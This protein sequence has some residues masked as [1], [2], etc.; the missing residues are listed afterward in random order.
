[1][2]QTYATRIRRHQYIASLPSGD[3]NSL[4][5]YYF[6]GTGATQNILSGFSSSTYNYSTNEIPNEITGVIF[7]P[8]EKHTGE[9]ISV[10]GYSSMGTD[11]PL[12]GSIPVT[13]PVNPGPN[14]IKIYSQNAMGSTAQGK[15]TRE[16]T[17]NINRA[18]TE[19]PDLAN[20]TIENLTTDFNVDS[21]ATTTYSLSTATG[22]RSVL[23]TPTAIDMNVSDITANVTTGRGNSHTISMANS[24]SSEIVV[25]PGENSISIVVTADNGTATQT[26]TLSIT[27]PES[28]DTS[29]QRIQSFIGASEGTGDQWKIKIGDG[30]TEID[31]LPVLGD[32]SSTVILKDIDSTIIEPISVNPSRYAPSVSSGND[33][34]FTLEVTAENGAIQTHTLTV[35]PPVSGG[36][37]GSG[38]LS[39]IAITMGSFYAT[40]RPLYLSFNSPVT[41][42]TASVFSPSVYDY[43]AVVYG[44]DS[45]KISATAKEGTDVS[46]ITVNGA[47][48]DI[49]GAT[50]TDLY[51]YSGQGYVTPV[52]I[53]VT[54]S[55]GGT[56]AY[57]VQ[58]KLLNIYEFYR[59]VYGSAM[60][61]TYDT[62]W[63]PIKPS[64]LG[65]DEKV[66]GT[67]SGKLHWYVK[68][69]S[70]GCTADSIMNLTNYNDGQMGLPHNN[71][72]IVVAGETL[73]CFTAAKTGYVT[74]GYK[75]Y[76]PE[77]DFVSDL[78]Y[79]LYAY[80]GDKIEKDDAYTDC[81]YMGETIRMK[82]YND[83]N[84]LSK[85]PFDPAYYP[86][87]DYYSSW[88]E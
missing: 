15:Y 87:Y 13:I 46:T 8:Y 43:S 14:A 26:Y 54:D 29:I 38:R 27:T 75:I 67:V 18:Y 4:D 9:H 36:G 47:D 59:G 68:S 5:V 55:S 78:G 21:P 58:V 37:S 72:G 61:I 20:L 41:D 52:Q 63:A 11:W 31:F 30:V 23:I 71:G 86:D 1:M 34:V 48:A 85:S 73:G 44:F 69:S 81:T 32:A 76:T 79:H 28:S 12:A 10:N 64:G 42:G 39:D 83:S 19:I 7:Q 45:I 77:G 60:N 40:P 35:S 51:L 65:A 2:S 22:I 17:V 57:V 50:P 6:D 25:E 70:N 24:E 74:K 84:P 33:T 80:K 3:I 53:V 16:Y 62:K 56:M 66:D 49:T 88:T 82:Y